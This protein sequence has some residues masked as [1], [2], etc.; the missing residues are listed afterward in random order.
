MFELSEK[1]DGVLRVSAALLGT[2]PVAVL[3]A[4]AVAR[5]LPFTLEA[6]FALGFWLAVAL[7]LTGMCVTFLA[8]HGLRAWLW[9]GG[10]SFLGWTLAAFPMDAAS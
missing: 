9:C 3:M 6:R 7:W 1:M 8:R 4:V 10:L 2:L 5:F